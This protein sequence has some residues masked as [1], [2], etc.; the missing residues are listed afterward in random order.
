MGRSEN[1]NSVLDD[2]K[3]LT[4][5]SGERMLS[6]TTQTLRLCSER[7]D[8]ESCAFNG[9]VASLA[10]VHH[11]ASMAQRG[12]YLSARAALVGTQRL[13]QRTMQASSA[14]N[15]QAY[16]SF[17]TAA[18]KLDGFMRERQATEL[19]FGNGCSG[20][21]RKAQRDD[22]AAKAMYQMKSLSTKSFHAHT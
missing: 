4:L 6:V 20:Q 12:E 19:V 1:L 2:N 8:A 3:L 11:A 22:E 14:D 7:D 15:Q 16:L 5:P 18:E 17:I 21:A 10:A 13:L 9:T